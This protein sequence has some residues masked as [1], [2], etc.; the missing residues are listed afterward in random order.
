MPYIQSVYTHH[1]KKRDFI[2]RR[3][4]LKS[5]EVWI[6]DTGVGFSCTL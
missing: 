6:P 3:E 1:T 2:N 5:Q 4:I